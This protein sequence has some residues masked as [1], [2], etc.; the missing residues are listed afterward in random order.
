[1]G[2]EHGSLLELAMRHMP[3]VVRELPSKINIIETFFESSR[4]DRDL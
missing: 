4:S 1:M 3:N 2:L